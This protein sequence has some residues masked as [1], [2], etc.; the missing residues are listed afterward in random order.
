MKKIA[1]ALLF[2]IIITGFYSCHKVVGYGPV[3]TEK[4]AT[5]HFTSINFGVPGDLYFTQ[6]S[7]YKIEIQGQENIIREIQTYI[8]GDELKI[9][10][11]DHTHLRSGEDIRI[12]IT[13]PSVTGLTLSGSGN[14]RILQPYQTPAAK[15]V[16]SGSGS[17]TITKLETAG[18]DAEVN[19]SGELFVLEGITKHEDLDISGSGRIDLAGVVAKTARTEIKGSGSMKLHVS[20]ELSNKISGSGTVYYKGNPV[21]N[22]IISGSGRVVR[23]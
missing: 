5:T 10:V 16:I 23:F 15:F 13:A 7:M 22:T 11:N 8:V 14:I 3:I 20:D 6:D 19:G 21:V 12:N 18:I 4:R 1:L 9:R 17:L 2:A